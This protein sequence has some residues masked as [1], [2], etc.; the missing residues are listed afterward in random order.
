MHF[1]FC[2]RKDSYQ[3]LK[4]VSGLEKQNDKKEILTAQK[5]T[6]WKSK[7]KKLGTKK[8][9]NEAD[10]TASTESL[11]IHNKQS[12]G[13]CTKSSLIQDNKC[14]KL[15]EQN[16]I[17]DN[18]C[19]ITENSNI[20]SAV[21]ISPASILKAALNKS[22]LSYQLTNKSIQ[23]S[24]N[25]SSAN[26]VKVPDII[27]QRKVKGNGN[28]EKTKKRCRSAESLKVQKLKK[29]I[30]HDIRKAPELDVQADTTLQLDT[31]LK[32]SLEEDKQRVAIKI[33]LCL[34]CSM[35]HLQDVCPLQNPKHIVSD[36]LTHLEWL[37]QYEHEFNKKNSIE[38]DLNTDNENE[39]KVESVNKSSYSYMS[40]PS[41]LFIK[42]VEGIHGLAVY[43]RS[44]IKQYTQFGPLV[45][46]TVKEV[47][48]PEDVNMKNLWE[49]YGENNHTFINT[50]SVKDS[51]WLKYIRP[52]P[53]REERNVAVV[54]KNGDLYV[55]TVRTVHAGEELLYWQDNIITTN[56]KKME[57]TSKH[58]L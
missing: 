39:E 43:A 54:C 37:Q 7:I 47:D 14:D 53:S 10:V 26:E 30:D 52:A 5:R 31:H 36:S 32:E 23:K 49:V 55:T 51:N 35:H 21:N 13:I 2:F 58:F 29:K 22:N 24:I 50:E 34:V 8:G 12:D 42:D 27:I 46:K 1:L 19:T 4:L 16:I 45:G 44:E 17:S 40:L 25:A 11:K 28:P 3:L 6:A 9:K 20:V 41:C 56:K 48:I 33:K 38:F 18:D 15:L 57:K